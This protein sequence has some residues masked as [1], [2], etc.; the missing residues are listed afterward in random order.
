MHILNKENLYRR[1]FMVGKNNLKKRL[2]QKAEKIETY[3]IKKFKVGTASV[4][5]GVGLF[6]G[7]E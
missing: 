1:K 5:I 6:F 7:A 2:E 3:S 4:L